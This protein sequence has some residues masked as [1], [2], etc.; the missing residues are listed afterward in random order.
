[1]VEILAELSLSPSL[2]RILCLSLRFSFQ[3]PFLSVLSRFPYTA[4]L[5][6]VSGP[7]KALCVGDVGDPKSPCMDQ[8][9][10]S[11]SQE[12]SVALLFALAFLALEQP[13]WFHSVKGPSFRNSRHSLLG[14]LGR[15][16]WHSQTCQELTL[17]TSH[18][19]PHAL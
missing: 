8:S 14:P 11:F 4:D 15:S 2:S 10:L 16:W 6:W 13:R 18:P 5:L 17:G 3:P 12:Q 1:V 7:F 9:C 19:G